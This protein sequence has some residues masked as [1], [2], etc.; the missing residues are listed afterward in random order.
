MKKYKKRFT[1]LIVLLTVVTI[2]L[3]GGKFHNNKYTNETYGFSLSYPK[4]LKE[5]K[6]TG[7]G[8][9]VVTIMK[10]DDTK[11]I[12]FAYVNS[13]KE[14]SLG[15]PIDKRQNLR[16]ALNYELTNIEEVTVGGV[17]GYKGDFYNNVIN[18]HG[19][20]YYIEHNGHIYSFGYDRSIENDK[21][22]RQIIESFVFLK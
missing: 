19:K 5:V 8:G 4:T 10:K 6:G 2:V 22:V 20:D 7:L 12:S 14:T 17:K 9:E 16:M 15:A 18:Y 11:G 1:V 3:L 21:E 13:L